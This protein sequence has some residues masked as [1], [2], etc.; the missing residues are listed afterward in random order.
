VL[1]LVFYFCSFLLVGALLVQSNT[2]NSYILIILMT[3]NNNDRLS[4]DRSYYCN[5]VDIVKSRK[6]GRYIYR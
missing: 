4:I 3:N 1:V 2:T 5:V 6:E